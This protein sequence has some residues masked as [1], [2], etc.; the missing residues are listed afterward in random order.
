MA[1]SEKVAESSEIARLERN[2]RLRNAFGLRVDV[3][4]TTRVADSTSWRRVAYSECLALNR[5]ESIP[6]GSTAVDAA[7]SRAE[8]TRGHPTRAS[9][10][11]GSKK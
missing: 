11:F 3:A 9:P 6:P 5:D 2:R 1:L 4:N 8:P 10:L 7:L